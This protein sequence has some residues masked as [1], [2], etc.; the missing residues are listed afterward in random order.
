MAQYHLRSATPEPHKVLSSRKTHPFQLGTHPPQYST[1][2]TVLLHQQPHSTNCSTTFVHL[3]GT[4]TLSL[5]W[6]KTHSSAYNENEVNFYDTKTTKITVL[7]EAVLKGWHCP[8]TNL[9]RVPLVPIVTN[10]NTDTLILDHPS[11]QNSLNSM[12]TIET[13]QI[14]HDHVAL[15]M[16]KNH[17]QEY[18]HNVYELPSV[19]PT[20]RYLHG[21]VSFPTKTSWLNAIRKRNYLSWPLINVK[22]VAKYFPESEETQ[23][24]HMRGQ[25][26]GVC[27]TRMTEPTK[28]IPTNIPHT[29]KGDILITEHEVKPLMY[30]D[31]TGLF[32]AVSS[33]GNKYVM[34][35]H[36]VDSNSS[37][38]E[39]M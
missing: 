31:Q 25:R 16:C 17:H 38:A 5:H 2:R 4:S 20:I 39:A 22:N 1:S 9:W 24:G 6:L 33:L 32:P 14:S 18:L 26:Q 36:H 27:S 29:K 8:R 11:G 37:W 13:N 15:Q 28:D 19:E 10:L 12:Y 3:P 23:R 21:V 35:L 30:A 7:A 34:I